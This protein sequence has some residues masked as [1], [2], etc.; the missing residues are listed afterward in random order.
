MIDCWKSS[1]PSGASALPASSSPRT[2]LWPSSCTPMTPVEQTAT[3]SSVVR[4]II[5]PAPCI[6]AASSMPRPPVAALAL[7]ELTATA[8]QRVQPARGRA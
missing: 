1:T 2:I 4:P 8:L 3:R 6:R 7:P 5:A